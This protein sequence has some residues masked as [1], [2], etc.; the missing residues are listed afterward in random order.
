MHKIFG[1][2]LIVIALAMAVVP[3]FTDC[4][5][6]GLE[7]ALPNGKTV[8]MKCH[9]TGQAEMALGAPILAVGAMMLTR[10]LSAFNCPN[11]NWRR[12][13]VML[14]SPLMAVATAAQWIANYVVS[15]T[16]PMMN[17]NVYLQEHFHKAFPYWIY[18]SFCLVALIFV[19]KFVPETKGKSLEEI[20][21]IWSK[22]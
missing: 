4:Q 9:W 15:Q 2:A 17:K 20:E 5:S 14:T 13:L 1:I 22:K 18:G 10:M 3:N 7:I 12:L 11:V 21:H 19:I 16:F 8:P 6:Q